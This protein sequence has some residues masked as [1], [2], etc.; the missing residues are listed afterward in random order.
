MS[1]EN[2][3]SA[4][5][6]YAKDIRLN[7]G[8]VITENGSKGLSLHQIYGIALSAGLATENQWLIDQLTGL[9]SET[10]GDAGVQAAHS[11]SS[12]M[13]M[14]NVYYRSTGMLSDPTFS[15]MQAGLRMQVLAN[16]GIDKVDFELNSLA[17]SAVNGC[18]YCVDSHAKKLMAEGISHEGIQST[19]KIAAVLTAVSHVQKI[20]Q[21][22]L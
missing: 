15:T 1:I 9:A 8:R 13:A 2:I 20:N 18:K 12:I 3:K 11:A 14:N 16:H 19:I 17:V 4:I 10:L 22:A 6:D 5:P 21:G 7:A